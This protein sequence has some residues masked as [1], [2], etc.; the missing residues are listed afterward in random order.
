MYLVILFILGLSCKLILKNPVSAGKLSLGKT[1]WLFG[2]LGSLVLI[3]LFGLE[4]IDV[5]END[6]G[7]GRATIGAFKALSIIL[8]LYG[9]AVYI[10]IWNAS[11]NHR[12]K[13]L[14]RYFGSC[15]VTPVL[16]IVPFAPLQALTFA[17]GVL[18]ARKVSKK[19][20]PQV[21]S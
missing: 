16:V 21:S 15:V 18:I 10:G 4:L 5:L 2:L 14:A 1:F 8:C 6:S 3:F 17:L 11:K 19:T 12:Y 9:I 13:V 20:D 7:R